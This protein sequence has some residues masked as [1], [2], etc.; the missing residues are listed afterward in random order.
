M[1]NFLLAI[2]FFIPAGAANVAPILA[3]R[4]PILKRLNAPLDFG[5]T[6]RGVP[7]LGPNKTWRGMLAGIVMAVVVLWLQ[8]VLIRDILRSDALFG[9]DYASL[10]TIPLGILFG[11]GALGGDALK[12]F[13]K[14]RVG[15]A[16]GRSWIPFDQLDYIIGAALA[17]VIVVRL[18]SLA[19]AWSV[20][21][22]VLIHFAATFVGYRAGLKERPV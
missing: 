8:Q 22:W 10:P 5:V 9:L 21:L 13:F 14:R 18:P 1:D 6:F 12:S 7:V 2:W 3:A 20:I 17:T 16:P 11:I 15:T 19:Y 4:V